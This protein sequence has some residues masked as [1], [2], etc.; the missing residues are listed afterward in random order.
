M[1]RNGKD[2][3][4]RFPDRRARRRALGVADALLDGEVAVVLPDGTTSFQ[5]LQNA[6]RR[7][8]PGARL[9]VLRLRPA[10]TSTAT[11]CAALPLEERKRV[12]RGPAARASRHRCATA[13]TS[14][15]TGRAFF[16]EACRMALEGIVSKRRDAPLPPGPH[17]DWLKVKCVREQEFVIG[18]F[19]EPK[20]AREGLGALL[21]GVYDATGALRYAGKVGTGFTATAPRDLRRRLGAP[22]PQATRPF[23]RQ[24][25]GIAARDLGG[26]AA[27]GAGA[28]HRVDAR[29]PPAPSRRS[30]ACAR[31]RRRAR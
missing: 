2:W 12:L 9:V 15:A 13:S 31:T 28:L 30:R 26:A 25:P 19:T 16:A 14:S 23:A 6:R 27:G 22:R 3:T 4:A 18:G 21:L 11:T 1:S 10:R 8:P 7:C 5:A 24:A 17:A 29:R 20:G